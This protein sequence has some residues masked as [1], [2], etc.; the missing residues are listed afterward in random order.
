MAKQLTT[1]RIF[2][3]NGSTMTSSERVMPQGM[4]YHPTHGHTHFD[5]WGIYSL[6]MQEQ[7]V[8]DPRQWPIINEGYTLGFCLMDY[9]SCSDGAVTNHCKD[10]KP[11]YNAG[12]T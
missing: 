4:T 11:V 12:I 7:G 10:D 8:S 2:H 5:Q 9:N 6:R 3:K 1:Q